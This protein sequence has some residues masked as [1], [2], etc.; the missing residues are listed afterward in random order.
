MNQNNNSHKKRYG[1]YFSGKKI[2]AQL[3][4]LL[5]K[6]STWE[7][8]VD[9]MAGTGDMLLTVIN[10]SQYVNNILGVEIDKNIADECKANLPEN[11]RV[12]CSDAF[13][14]SDLITADGWELVITNPP[15]VRYQLQDSCD[16]IMP[17]RNEIR[18][19]LLLMIDQISY[20]TENE[21]KL[22]CS[23][24]NNYSGLSDMAV[25]AWILCAALVKKGGYLAMVVPETWLTREYAMPIQYLLSKLFNIKKVFSC[26]KTDSFPNALVKTNLIIAKRRNEILLKDLEHEKTHVMQNGK[27]EIHKTINLF[28]YFYD[29]LKS[30]NWIKD[31]DKEFLDDGPKAAQLPYEM[32]DMIQKNRSVKYIGLKELR[33]DC[34][35]GLRTGANEFFYV[36][37]VNS[38]DRECFVKSNS[39][40]DGGKLYSVPS[41]MI[42][43]TL[44]NRNDIRGLTVK[45]EQLCSGLLLFSKTATGNIK[46]YVLSAENYRDR[47]G[48]SFKDYTAVSPNE[49]IINGHVVKEWYCLPPLTSRH[50]PNLCVPRI[51]AKESECLYIE[52]KQ[53]SPIA[54]D[55][56]MITLWGDNNRDVYISMAIFNSTWVKLLLEL[57]CNVMGGGALKIE[58]NNIK[59]IVVPDLDKAL[60]DRLEN[61]GSKL[62]ELN[63]MNSNIQNEID[64]II[65]SPFNDNQLIMK[66]RMLLE[67]KISERSR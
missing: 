15:Y 48:R 26:G 65:F 57:T 47:K 61:L 67:E 56:N 23:V 60:F 11:C 58:A 25:P 53:S 46:K 9:P 35:Q 34:G 45:A 42:I 8:V 37:I 14:C 36:Q 27:D 64:N 20:L 31:K 63:T 40:D 50:L 24:A 28:P 51:T 10:K 17:S 49:K 1:Q 4:D 29:N 22:F 32:L 54:V 6:K 44:R 33:M 18:Q 59:K 30:A 3:Y 43:R 52:Q 21:K 7:N 39:W 66:S 2:S 16:K 41:Q 62:I 12:V 38:Q 19:N 55:A 5:P 13:K